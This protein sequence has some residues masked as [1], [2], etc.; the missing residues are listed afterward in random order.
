MRRTVG[1]LACVTVL[2]AAAAAMAAPMSGEFEPSDEHQTRNL[3]VE[4]VITKPDWVKKPDAA[5][6]SRFY[7]PFSTMLGLSGQVRLGCTVQS[8]GV[9]KDCSVLSETPTGFGFGAA[10]LGMAPLFQMKPQTVDGAPVGGAHVRIPINFLVPPR[11]V[12][13]AP[14][15]GGATPSPAVLALARRMAERQVPAMTDAWREQ[16]TQG[17]VTPQAMIALNCL[18]EAFK[19]ELPAQRERYAEAYARVYTEEELKGIVEFLESPAGRAYASRA[20]EFHNV[21]QSSNDLFMRDS[22]SAAR[23]S[24]CRQIACAP[25]DAPAAQPGAK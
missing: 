12:R 9:L 15:I 16:A 1:V 23:E 24:L 25:N 2:A 11:P 20:I 7:P 5:D 18:E 17:A 13:D 10:A 8:T 4:G 6:V 21:I 22:M 19:K 3:P 14:A